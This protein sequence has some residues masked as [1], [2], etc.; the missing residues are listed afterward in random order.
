MFNQFEVQQ[1]I[2]C[3]SILRTTGIIETCRAKT[4]CVTGDGKTACAFHWCFLRKLTLK[5]NTYCSI[6]HT[7]EAD[8]ERCLKLV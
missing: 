5:N 2:C 3:G 4:V 6:L 1:L 8:S 7:H